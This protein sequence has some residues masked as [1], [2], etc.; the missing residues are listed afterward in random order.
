MIAA[1][2]SFGDWISITQDHIDRGR[3][4]DTHRCAVALAL[5]D[6]FNVSGANAGVTTASIWTRYDDFPKSFDL[7][8]YVS[9]W[10]EAFDGD[11]SRVKPLRFRLITR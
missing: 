4:G 2:T 6:H 1:G 3:P 8:G 9:T 10:I 5:I 7:P 11:K